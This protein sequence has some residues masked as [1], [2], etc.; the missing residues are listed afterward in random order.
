MYDTDYDADLEVSDDEDGPPQPENIAYG[1]AHRLRLS[2][3]LQSE[4]L[5]SYTGSSNDA[6]NMVGAGGR[7]SYSA[8]AKQSVAP[9]AGRVTRASGNRIRNG[10]AVASVQL[11]Q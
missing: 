11:D 6:R 3:Q 4:V 8:P 1:Q 9:S 5:D 10:V 7:A 2:S